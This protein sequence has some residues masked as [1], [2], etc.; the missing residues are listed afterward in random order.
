MPDILL[1]TLNAKYIHSAFGLRCLL[2]NLGDL[3]DR[4]AIQE[5]TIHEHVGEIVAAIVAQQPRIVGFGVYI[6]NVEQVARVL[7]DL[8]QVRPDVM[9]VVGGPEVS[10]ETEGQPVVGL[11]DYVITG[12]ADL[13]FRDLCTRLLAGER[14]A[15]RIVH[16]PVPDLATIRL[17][18]DHYSAED[19][20]HRVLYVEASRGCPFTCEFCLSALEIPVRQFP[21]D[22]FLAS[23][24]Q[25]LD[26]GALQ[27]KFVD[28]TFNLNLRVSRAILGFFLERLR[29]GMFLH[30]EMIP[31]RL[32]DGLKSVI[33][34]FPPG[35]LQFEI[36]VQ[37][38]N[39][40]VSQRISRPQ[41]NIALEANL[42]WLRAETGVH[43]HTDLIVGLPGESLESF[44]ESFD[45]L[46]RMRPHEIQ[47]GVLKRLKGTPIVRHDAEWQVAWSQSAP[48]DILSNRLLP[49]DVLQRLKRF[50]RY[51]DL[52]GNSGRFHASLPLLVDRNGSPF[53]S[54]LEFSDWLF[55]V[56]QR[57]HGIALDRLAERC[58]EFLTSR[59]GLP[60]AVVAQAVWTD[61]R[62]SGRR[63]RP[64]FLREF[65]L[66]SADSVGERSQLPARQQRFAQSRRRPK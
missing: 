21:L 41:D 28:R 59:C 53:V 10:Y 58:F 37:T 35:V 64:F 11:A 55:E 39:D 7:A 14:P 22:G 52:V 9:V 40:T 34:R 6:W 60:A 44:A 23:M 45:R 48:Y 2:A 26:R 8:R 66:D 3:Q 24:Q 56:E 32:P 62:T 20:A 19:I 43:L 49:F 65:Q 46:W 30:F 51:W 17:P 61:L 63:D 42:S 27:F 1:T 5:F 57:R 33:A 29:P 50:A 36:G 16:A 18:Y 12:E 4:A 13:A 31:D 25:L 15:D 54:F 47:V 38:L